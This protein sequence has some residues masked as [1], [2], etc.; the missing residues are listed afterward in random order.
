MKHLHKLVVS[1]GTGVHPGWLL[2]AVVGLNAFWVITLGAFDTQFRQLAGYP[3]LDLQNSI[4]PDA[5]MTPANMRTQIASYSQEAKTLYWSFFILDN[6]MPPLAF[7]S[8]A[9]MWVSLLHS[10][11]NRLYTRLLDSYVVLIPVGVGIFD[12]FENLGY[13]A[14]IHSTDSMTT[15]FAIYAGLTF[16]WIKAACVV[17]TFPILLVL[18][19]VHCGYL[20]RRRLAWQRS[21]VKE[22]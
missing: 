2:I 11:P 3:L 5:V 17:P 14:A 1:L 6:I 16:K 20:L 18:G 15:T 19:M 12:W 13:I 9:L 22:S 8:V 21:L 4:S 10:N 7:S